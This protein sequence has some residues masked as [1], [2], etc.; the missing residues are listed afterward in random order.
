M[1]FTRRIAVSFSKGS[2]VMNIRR[3][4]ALAA[5]TGLTALA[6]SVAPAFAAD[7]RTNYVLFSPGSESVSMSGSSDDV[8][9]ARALR[10]GNEA[11]LYVREGDV[12]YVIR[13][14]ATLAQAR[15]I[16]RPQEEVGARQGELGRRQGELGRQ[17]GLLGA[18]QGRLGA[19]Q[20][21]SPPRVAAELA[22]QQGELGRRQGELGRQ[23]G[24]LG[25]QQGELGREQERL[26]R[27][28]QDKLRALVADAIRRGI[29]QRVN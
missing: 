1:I 18:E 6:M 8:R 10:R 14:P 7:N 25:R 23:Q 26:A 2:T 22:I 13:D 11:L 5:L 21:N 20:A 15:A 28:A 16:F 17:Q 24:E 9:R 12:A 3:R 19:L 29:S 27:I 4:L